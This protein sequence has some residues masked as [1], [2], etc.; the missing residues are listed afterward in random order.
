MTETSMNAYLS[1]RADDPAIRLL[2]DTLAAV[3]TDPRYIAREDD[4]AAA[5]FLDAETPADLADEALAHVLARIEAAAAQD[6]RAAE[7]AA[8]GDP[9][10]AE[11]AALPSPVREAALKALE[12]DHWRFGSFGLRRLPLDMGE[13][14]CE[15]MRIEPGMGAADHDHGGDELT[16]ILTGAYFDGH[17]D[18]A[19]GDLSLARGGF[20]HAPKAKP[21]EVC[22]VLAVTYGEA[23]FKGLIGILQKLI[24]FPGTPKPVPSR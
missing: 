16:L 12:H 6:D 20:V 19:A 8:Y 14:H 18:Y 3:R 23:R 13:T 5:V 2:A 4:R 17:A 22:Y 24:G 11:V 21:G 9:V 7:R 15:L 10:T 1:A